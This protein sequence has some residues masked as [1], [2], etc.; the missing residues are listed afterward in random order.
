MFIIKD[1]TIK[2]KFVF[3]SFEDLPRKR[4]GKIKRYDW[5]N[6]FMECKEKLS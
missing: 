4:L 1:S 5:K 2:K 6:F 3:I